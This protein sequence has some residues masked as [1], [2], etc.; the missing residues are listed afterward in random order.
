MI[1]RAGSLAVFLCLLA[2]AVSARAADSPIELMIKRG[3]QTPVREVTF[4]P[5]GR[6]IL[7][8]GEEGGAYVAEAESGA[9][10]WRR[11]GEMFRSIG[12]SLDG[13]RIV[14]SGLCD[15][16]VWDPV[17]NERIAMLDGQ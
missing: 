9:E 14:L 3:P 4:S 10:V 8:I 7:T 16:S 11:D 6:L 5:D 13:R 12:S 15:V 17:T 1:V 2:P